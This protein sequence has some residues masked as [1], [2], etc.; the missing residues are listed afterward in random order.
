M[1]M[2]RQPGLCLALIAC[3]S[4]SFA[5]VPDASAQRPAAPSRLAVLDVELAGDLGGPELAAAH[6]S[7]LKMASAK[8]REGLSGAGLYA[9]VD[10]APAQD[11]IDRLKSQH[12]YLHDCNGCDLEVGRLL[13][14]DQVLVAWVDRVSGLILTLTYEIHDVKTGQIVARKSFG[15]RGDND[16]A[17][18]RAIDYMVRDLRESATQASPAGD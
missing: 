10:M 14:A 2:T 9:L 11:V 6:E 12:L 8:L 16:V 7:R 5:A 15:F 17:W 3:A 18:T 13:A 4:S 1:R